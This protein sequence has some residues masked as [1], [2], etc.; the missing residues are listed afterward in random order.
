MLRYL[1]RMSPRSR[2]RRGLV[3]VAGDISK[4]NLLYSHIPQLTYPRGRQE[5][6]TPEEVDAENG[7]VAAEEDDEM[8]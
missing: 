6:A 4:I 1:L 7:V 3:A 8:L 5:V 2:P